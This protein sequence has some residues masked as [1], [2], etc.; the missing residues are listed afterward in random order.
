M[1]NLLREYLERKFPEPDREGVFQ[2]GPVVTVSREFG[3]PSKMIAQMLTDALNKR[4]GIVSRNHWRFINKEIVEQAARELNVKPTD[5]NFLLSSPDKGLIQDLMTSFSQTY[6][7]NAR[8]RKTITNAIRSA[9][10]QGQVVLVGRGGVGILRNCP[11]TLHIR[12]SAPLE[13]RIPEICKLRGINAVEARKLAL[14]TDK[15]RSALIEMF[16]GIKFH[17]YLFDITYNCSTMT[18][19]EIVSTTI[20]LMAARRLIS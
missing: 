7:S 20:S 14:E 13:W 5:M 15:K 8:I 11:N 3:C 4:P 9:A 12:L 10:R 16:S 19:E 18:R 1:E 17:P 6:V 2:N